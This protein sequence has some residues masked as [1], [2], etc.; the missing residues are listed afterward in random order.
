LKQIA[1]K[2]L[3]L[4]VFDDAAFQ[5]QIDH[6]ETG[7]ADELTFCFTDGRRKSCRWPPVKTENC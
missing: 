5:K 3:G 6:I 2:V 7:K 4:S 1:A